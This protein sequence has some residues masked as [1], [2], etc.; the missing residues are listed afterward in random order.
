MEW[1]SK[2]LF[3]A[4]LLPSDGAMLVIFHIQHRK[5]EDKATVTLYIPLPGNWPVL[6]DSTLMLIYLST[7]ET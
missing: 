6:P 4:Y 3:P 5:K 7:E 1:I 2:F